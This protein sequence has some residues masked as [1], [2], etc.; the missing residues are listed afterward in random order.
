VQE[1]FFRSAV[2]KLKKEGLPAAEDWRK[3]G[4]LPVRRNLSGWIRF[5]ETIDAQN[6]GGRWLS[7]NSV[8]S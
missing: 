4:R 7:L 8:A 5:V 3:L 2:H 1:V 6:V